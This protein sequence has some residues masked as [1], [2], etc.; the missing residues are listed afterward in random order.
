MKQWNILV[1]VWLT[2]GESKKDFVSGI[3]NFVYE[4]PHELPNDLRFFKG[5]RELGNIRKISKVIGGRAY[6]PVSFLEIRS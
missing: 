3:L 1:Y 5:L 2:C 6:C 4:L